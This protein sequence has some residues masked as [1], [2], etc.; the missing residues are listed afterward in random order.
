[1]SSTSDNPGPPEKEKLRG[2]GNANTNALGM[3]SDLYVGQN[4]NRAGSTLNVLSWVANPSTTTFTGDIY[5]LITDLY[6][7]KGD[8]YPSSSDYMG[9]FQFGTEAFRAAQNVTFSVPKFSVDIE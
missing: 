5:P 6:T 4:T 8:V 2:G 1:M 3:H 9:I 7:L